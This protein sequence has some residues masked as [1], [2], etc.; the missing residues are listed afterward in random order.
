MNIMKRQKDMTLK[1]ELPKS[2][3]AQDAT[4]EEQRNSSKKNEEAETKRK[5]HP[6]VDVTLVKVK[7]NAVKNNT[8]QEPGMLGP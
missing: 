4:A 3:G 2:I 7:S 1:D 8:A 5:Q 6:V